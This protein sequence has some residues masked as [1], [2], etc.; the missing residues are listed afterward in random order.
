M[1]FIQN[2][3]PVP[4]ERECNITFFVIKEGE[5]AGLGEVGDMRRTEVRVSGTSSWKLHHGEESI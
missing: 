2:P 1:Q 5:L 3:L 4:T